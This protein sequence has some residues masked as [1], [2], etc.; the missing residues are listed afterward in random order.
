ML[1]RVLNLH[2]R[3]SG[4]VL[5]FHVAVTLELHAVLRPMLPLDEQVYAPVLEEIE[6]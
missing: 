2:Q 1:P 4:E 3:V 6:G 5:V